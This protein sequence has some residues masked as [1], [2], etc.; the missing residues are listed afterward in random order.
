M[1]AG[2]T[3]DRVLVRL[4]ASPAEDKTQPNGKTR[5]DAYDLRLFREGQLVSR[6]PD[7]PDGGDGTAAVATTGRACPSP[8]ARTH[9]FVGGCFLLKRTEGKPVSF[10]AYAFNEDRVKSETATA[11]YTV[12]PD[13]TQRKPQAYVITVG[14]DGY[15]APERTLQFAVSDA[16]AMHTALSKLEGY[17]VEA[18]SLTS[19]VYLGEDAAKAEIREVLARLAGRTPTPGTLAG[20][21]GADRLAKATPDDLVIVTFSGHG[22]TQ[23][24][25][26][27]YLLG[28]D[29][30]RRN[31]PL[32]QALAKF[33]SSEELSEWLRP[34]DAGEMALIIDACHSAAKRNQPGFK[35]GPMGD[36]GL[37]QLAY[38][39][40]MRILAAS[41]AEDVALE[42]AQLKHG[43]LTYALA[44]DGLAVGDE[45][46]AQR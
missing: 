42:S 16:E 34:I 43:L 1:S 5:T 32:P 17:E 45:R 2:P 18:M 39:K 19:G 35:P 21:A 11:S 33:I 31:E 12:P 30:G 26:T 25:G 28:S 24:D 13:V 4:T 14:A 20:V 3:P 15:D 46:Q 23:E 27:F 38:D 37:G 10:T 29:L 8:K 41:Q 7:G 6:W 22:Y 36:R 44:V 40:A 9:E